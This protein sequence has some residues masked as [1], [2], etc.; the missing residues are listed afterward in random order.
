MNQRLVELRTKKSGTTLTLLGPQS[1]SIYPP[2]Y[3]WLYVLVNG[4]PGKG[5]RVMIGELLPASL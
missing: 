5:R 1:R 2:G 3:A 4:V